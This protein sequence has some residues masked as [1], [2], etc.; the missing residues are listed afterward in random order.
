MLV[1][2]H[3]EEGLSKFGSS[4]INSQNKTQPCFKL[5]EAHT[6]TLLTGL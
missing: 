2:I 5:D 1:D 6:A 3:G 4:Y